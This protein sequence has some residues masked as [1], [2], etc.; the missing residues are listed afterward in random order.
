MKMY[1]L[2][3]ILVVVLWSFEK[4]DNKEHLTELELK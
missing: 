4:N 3:I 1:S 2:F